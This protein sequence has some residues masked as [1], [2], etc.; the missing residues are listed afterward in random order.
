MNRN[1]KGLHKMTANV[2]SLTL[3][4][5]MA[6]GAAGEAISSVQVYAAETSQTESVKTGTTVYLNGTLSGDGKG[7]GTTK[8][9]AVSSIDTALKLAGS[10]GTILVCG[11]V[12]ISSEKTLSIP[13]G[14]QIKRAQNYTGAIIKI[15]GKGKLTLAGGSLQAADVDTSGAELG[16]GAFVQETK[17]E[18]KKDGQVSMASQVTIASQEAW[19]SFDFAAAGFSGEGTFSWASQT[20]PAEYQS[21]VQVIFTPKD[22]QNYDYSKV[23]GW[24]SSQNA[25][26]RN[27]EVTIESLKPVETVPPAEEETAQPPEETVQ[28]PDTPETTTPEVPDTEEENTQDTNT[29]ENSGQA[30]ETGE[31]EEEQTAAQVT[32]PGEITLAS[33]E[34]IKKFDFA[35]AGFSGE[36]TFSWEKEFVPDAYETEVKVVFTPSDTE[37]KDYTQVEGWNEEKGQ[38]IRT[39]KILVESLKK[40]ASDTTEEKEENT[41]QNGQKPGNSP[42]GEQTPSE[43]NGNSDK[44]QTG[45]DKETDIDKETDTA[46]EASSEETDSVKEDQET[47]DQ[48][49]S[50]PVSEEEE[51]VQAEPGKTGEVAQEI[52]QAVPVGSLIDANTGVRVE[53]DFLPYYVDLQVSYNEDLDQLPDAGIGQILSA[54]EIKLWDLKEDEEYT[55]PEGKKVR[56]MIPLPE[57][58]G[59]FSSLSVAHYLGNSEYEYYTLPTEEYPG[60]LAVINIEGMDYLTF[61]TASFSPFNVGGSQLVGPGTQIPQSGS[62]SNQSTGNSSSGGNTS[63]AS[64]GTSGNSQTGSSGTASG[65]SVI[66]PSQNSGT[67][68]GSTGSQT[69]ST[70]KNHGSR[71]TRVVRTGDDTPIIPY[72]AAGAAAVILGAAAVITGKKKKS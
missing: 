14:V 11:P 65:Q 42:E 39:V 2:L 32:M 51:F 63:G 31:P 17:T 50:E 34:E 48:E 4:S 43:E 67:S 38:V 54:Y 20:A 30:G 18:T 29:E 47:Q 25:V 44:E 61:E 64:T 12:T 59:S 36:G 8:E 16:T 27:V 6:A 7:D 10:Q 53:G 45:T 46:P 21:T 3:A 49:E 35:K 22:T 15:T 9:K 19:S 66:Q 71:V 23:Q 52:P 60:T 28:Q 40:E 56:V 37:K 13:S 57:N 5:V 68:T 1:K 69:S 72:A 24:D 41:D 62:S 26:I 55:I 33:P 58:A 70:A